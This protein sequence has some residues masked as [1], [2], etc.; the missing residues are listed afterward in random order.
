MI[1]TKKHHYTME[2]L[3]AAAMADVIRDAEFAERQAINGP[4][5]PERGI[6]RESLLAY[7]AKCR[8]EAERF[9]SGGM[10]RA[11]LAPNNTTR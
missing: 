6:S 3:D 1:Y 5:Y 8:I 10:H 11:L 7:G 2:E 9:K 4:Y